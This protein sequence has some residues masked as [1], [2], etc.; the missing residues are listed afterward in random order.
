MRAAVVRALGSPQGITIEEWP[1]PVPEPGQVIVRVLAAGVNYADLLM[2]AGHYQVKPPLPFVPGV[3]FCGLITRLGPGV[4]RW[5]PGDR[6]MGATASGGCFAEEVAV[7]AERIFRAPESLPLELAAQLVVAH[8]T[9]AYALSRGLLKSGETVLVSGAGGGVGIATVGIAARLGARVLAAAG[10]AGKLR[11]AQA[12]GA[13]AAIPYQTGMLRSAVSN[14]TGGAGVDVVL[15]TV[16]GGFFDEALRCLAPHGRILVVGFASG[17]LPRIPAEYLLLKNLSA[18]GIG[19]GGV[20]A[21]EPSTA[22]AIIEEILALHA[23]QPFTAEVG[24]Q[25]PLEQTALALQRLADRQ[26]IGKQLILPR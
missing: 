26:V 1:T 11:V 15:D 20:L 8:G 7:S 6:V 3:E 24:G 18:L 21:R 12:H 16:G 17:S 23:A 22:Q 25:L 4:D 13:H 14:L 2:V 5:S 19:F 10:S 9:A